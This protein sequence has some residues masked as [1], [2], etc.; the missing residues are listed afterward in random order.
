[1]N[2]A[3]DLLAAPLSNDIE[4]FISEAN[5][6]YKYRHSTNDLA[7]GRNDKNIIS[8]LYKPIKGYEEFTNERK[9]F[10]KKG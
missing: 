7:I 1:M 8:T 2:T 5:F 10:E 4:G 9:L 3:R 6:I